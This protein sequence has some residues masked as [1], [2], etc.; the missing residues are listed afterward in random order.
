[1]KNKRLDVPRVEG[2]QELQPQNSTHAELLQNVTIDEHTGAWDSR[3]GYERYFAR[4]SSGFTPW[5]STPRID[6]VYYWIK[7]NG[8]LDVVLYEE[9]GSV[10]LLIEY[11]GGSY[12]NVNLFTTEACSLTEPAAQYCEFGKW[13]IITNGKTAPKKFAG[14]PMPPAAANIPLYDVGFEFTP[15]APRPRGLETDPTVATP[16]GGAES[17]I[18]FDR[19]NERGQGLGK[20][21]NEKNV[22]QY[23]ISFVSNTG[24]ESPLSDI[25]PP[26]IWT[27]PAASNDF[28][29][30]VSLEIPTGGADVVARNIYRTTNDGTIFYLIDTVR[31][32]VD[33]IYQDI[34]R[35]EIASA[36]S[37]APSLT[38]SVPRPAL[39]PKFC[40]TFSSCL[41]L[42][43]GDSDSQRLYFSNPLKPDQFGLLNFLELSTRQG[44]SI[45]GLF[46]YFN[47]LIVMRQNCIDVV[48]GSFP[49][50]TS[51][52]ILENIG[53]TAVNSIATIPKLGVVFATY[54]GVYLFAGNLEY[55]DKPQLQKISEAIS[56][57]W[58]RVNADQLVRSAGSYSWKTGEY[59]LYV[60]VDGSNV[61]NLGLVFHV[62]RMSW[63]SRLGFPV[64]C[65]TTDAAGNLIFGHHTGSDAGSNTKRGLFVITG[66]RALGQ[67]IVDD[68]PVD[69]PAPTWAFKS[70]WL[71]FGSPLQK[72]KVH[73]VSLYVLTTG[74]HSVSLTAYKDFSYTGTSSGSCIMQRPD[75]N[76]QALYDF[77]LLG[78]SAVWDSALLTEIRYSVSVGSCSHFQFEV[79]GT[80]DILLLGYSVD[81]MP[82]H[83]QIVRG[84]SS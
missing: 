21:E 33:T 6:S 47:F 81:Y 36:E 39:S 52:T 3:I 64:G 41:F 66:R 55:S 31:N 79:T 58:K 49:N 77:S 43:G 12:S 5:T 45:T 48:T 57:T 20:A 42:D 35:G 84:R 37:T 4:T 50:F 59:H 74:S 70:A 60:C 67:L 11:N 28:Q 40:A 51:Q 65:L 24:S 29:Y 30:G 18:F 54:E 17:C 73:Y 8:A 16:T 15:N 63:T 38:A 61:P 1:M 72:K 2:M 19:D 32:N 56:K 44:G 14:W 75:Y 68:V 80:N 26:I 46:S 34:T 10:Y 7:R 13:L 82:S 27:T 62:E 78:S 22:F 23:R 71:D 76:N 69:Q 9:Q 53:S 25:S 83:T